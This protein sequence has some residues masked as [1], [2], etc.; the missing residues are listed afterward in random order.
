MKKK[1]MVEDDDLNAKDCTGRLGSYGGF[2]I[3]LDDNRKKIYRSEQ[4]NNYLRK[5]G[6]SLNNT[7][8]EFPIGYVRNYNEIVNWKN[9]MKFKKLI[10]VE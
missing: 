3:D 2:Y 5:H 9:P 10:F 4:F 8:L 6:R 7:P 1:L